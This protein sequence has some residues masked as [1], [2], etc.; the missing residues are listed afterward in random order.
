[1]TLLSSGILIDS[2]LKQLGWRIVHIF[3]RFFINLFMQP[4]ISIFSAIDTRQRAC[5]AFKTG[6]RPLT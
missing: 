4:D 5:A 2:S 3:M 6:T 1:M